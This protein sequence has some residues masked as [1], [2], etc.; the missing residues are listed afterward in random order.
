MVARALDAVI[1]DLFRSTL[2]SEIPPTG[3]IVVAGPSGDDF[4]TSQS[5]DTRSGRTE[6]R[7]IT[8]SSMLDAE[9]TRWPALAQS[10]KL[11][12]WVWE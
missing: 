7:Q 3:E 2:S 12:Q 10:F 4:S 8:L 9:Y 1:G 6:R 11:E 5:W